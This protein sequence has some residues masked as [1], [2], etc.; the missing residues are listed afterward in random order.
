MNSKGFLARLRER[1]DADPDLTE[2]GLSRAAGLDPS[3][4]RQMFVKG[5]S[6]RLQ[7]MEAICGAL[8]TTVEQ[9]LSEGLSEEEQRVLRLLRQMSPPARHRFLGFGEAVVEQDKSPPSGSPQ[10]E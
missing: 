9:F 2:A 4:I 3:T 10:D 5:R 8:G 6:P 7:T 1:I